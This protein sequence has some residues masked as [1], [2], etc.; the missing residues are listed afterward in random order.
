V[1]LVYGERHDPFT[2]TFPPPHVI[3][4]PP[5][6]FASVSGST[7]IPPHIK[8]Q[9]HTDDEHDIGA[10]HVT[11]QPP[12]FTGS[13]VTSRHDPLQQLEPVPHTL[14]HEPQ[15]LLFERVLTS[16][17]SLAVPLQLPYP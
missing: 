11:P 1:Y 16:Q 9:P 4:Q 15:L 2:H 13:V 8:G 7:Q 10:T 12:Q 3:P 17:P 5:Q 14:P 6:L